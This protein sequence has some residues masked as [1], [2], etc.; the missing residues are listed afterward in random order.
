MSG[1]FWFRI[2]IALFILAGVVALGVFAYNLGVARGATMSAQ[3]A[4][5][6]APPV[7]MYPYGFHRPLGW[8][9]L[10][11]GVPLLLAF[12]FF[13]AVRRM[14]FFRMMAFGGPRHW[15]VS[16][17]WGSG[18]HGVG[19]EHIPPFVE[20]WHRKMHETQPPAADAP[21]HKG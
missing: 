16:R 4:E 15:H 10:A 6:P 7:G 5:L 13:G 14:M 20:E 9:L 19:P 2:V 1:K 18:H 8:G 21:E 17:H 12:L 3:W 11:L